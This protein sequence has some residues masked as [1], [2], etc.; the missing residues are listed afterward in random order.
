[1]TCPDCE[2]D[3][4]PQ[5]KF[6]LAC[7]APLRVTCPSCAH[8]NAPGSRFCNKCGQPLRPAPAPRREETTATPPPPAAER[9]QLTVMFC[10]LVGSTAIAERLDPEELREVVRAYQEVASQVIEQFEGHIAQ[11]LGDGLLVYFG[12]PQAH[13]DDP[14]RAVCAGVG[15]VEAIA[16]LDTRLRARLDVRLA[17]R[18]GIHTGLVVVGEVGGGARQEHLA[19]GG[20]PNLASRLQT[21]AEPGTV[22][23]SGGTARLV[24]GRFALRDLGLET[25]KGVT[26]P[27]RVY[28]VLGESAA[29]RPLDIES[30][31]T[32]LVGREHEVQLLL[33]RWGHVK[34]GQGQVVLLSGEPGIGKSRLVQ[35]VKDRLGREPHNRLE[36]RCSPYHRHS[37]FHPVIDL[38]QRA[39]QL[40]REDSAEQRLRKLEV[41]LEQYRMGLPDAVPLFASLLSLPMS[42]RYPALTL[43]PLRQRKKILGA[44]LALLAAVAAERPVLLIVEDLHWVD[45]STL[46]LLSLLV[47]QVP[48]AR[49]LALMTA[50][51]DFRPPWAPRSHLMQ[52]NLTRLSQ[53]QVSAMVEGVTA[54]KSLPSSLLDAI[55]AKTDGVPFYV[56]ELTRMVVE[57]GLVREAETGYELA[58]PMAPLAIPATLHDSLLARLDRLGAAK[59]VAQLAASLGR[60]FTHEV[61]QALSA[62]DEGAL[63]E[64]LATLVDTELLH[65]SG[66]PPRAKYTFRHALMQ[67]AAY[68]SL[69][70]STRQQYHHRI[71]EVLADRFPEIVETQP[72]LLAHH[73]TEAGRV[74]QAVLYWKRAGRQAS[75]RSACL[76][77]IAHLTK[78]LE[79]LDGLSDRAARAQHELDLQ[80]I[81]APALMAVRSPAAPEVEQAYAR[82]R[83]LCQQIGATPKLIW[84]LEGLWAFYFVRAK[85]QAARELGEQILDLALRFEAPRFLVV[86]HQ[87]LGT[88][89]LHQGELEPALALLEKG[90]ALAGREPEVP[91]AFREVNDPGVMCLAF[92]GQALCLLGSPD[93]ALAKSEEALDLARRFGHP[94]TRAFALCAAVLVSLCRGD[95]RAAEQ[96]AEAAVKLAREQ[97]FPLWHAT[98]TI[99]RGWALAAEGQGEEGIAQLRKGLGAWDATGAANLR[100]YFLVLLAD[101]CRRARRVEE[102]R[103]AVGEALAGIQDTGERLWEA[104]AHRLEGELSLMRDVGDAPAAEASLKRAF[105]CAR[106]QGARLF[107]LRAATSLGRLLG[108]QGRREEARR[109]LGKAY[110]GFSEGFETADL[111]EARALLDELSRG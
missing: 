57:S 37:A 103:A 74:E 38:L 29:A 95:A 8:V 20:T 65:Q 89:L 18:V 66:L 58:G 60:E 92:Q 72:E 1:M 25:P 99:L 56:E 107:E 28:Q 90:A 24:H 67:D 30:G 40:E 27:I 4:P 109:L 19:L 45:P 61:I 22:V 104:E 47:D 43:S 68:Q 111:R 82:A 39:L 11:Y 48:T 110:G 59:P 6:C 32:P 41:A 31:L 97:G 79:L 64:A 102:G 75:A 94:F 12:Y 26:A 106:R 73:Y 80:T 77:A 33:E 69:L 21:L 85:Y 81:L 16:G 78:G 17:V 49:I 36:C 34:E 14:R 15:I 46:E 105:D 101:A 91:G 100:P 108:A 54:G 2:Q 53:R 23:I 35:V 13:E 83:E 76:E 42:D 52:V 5:A 44:L 87:A 9:R 96:Q 88:T 7:G 62:L 50:R 71:A 84:A 51:P 93:R 63:E 98:G 70:R 3:N 86:G 10:D 55:A